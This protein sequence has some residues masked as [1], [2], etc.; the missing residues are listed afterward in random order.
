MG[1]EDWIAGELD[2][3]RREGLERRPA[4]YPE[5]GGK[6]TL[7]GKVFLNLASNDYLDLSRHPAVISAAAGALRVFGAGATA[8]RLVTGTLSIHCELEAALAKLKGYPA[9]LAF[10]SGY[11]AN[12]GVIASLAGRD[13]TVLVDKLAH[14]SILDAV[15]LSRARLQRFRHNDVAHLEELLKKD[16]GTGR[17]LVVTESVFS[18]DGDIAPL[19]DIAAAASKASAMLMVDEAHATGVFGPGGSG[20]VRELGL[21]QDVN[22]SMGTLSK[23]LGGYGGF[24][25]CSAQMRELMINTARPF[26]FSTG[27]PPA[28]AASALAAIGVMAE[29]PGMGRDLLENAARLRRRLR[30]AGLDTGS[31]SSQIVPV[32]VGENHIAVEMAERLKARGILVAAIRP[33]TVP[34]GTARLRLSVSLAH[35]MADLDRA[36][37]EVILAVN[38]ARAR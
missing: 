6:I 16:C 35:S 36:A 25:A 26:I 1:T 14:A 19:R 37:D 11:M 9:A 33:P 8:S 32:I 20:L 22:V 4:T 38:A 31:S 23:A 2:S 21:E 29:R 13:D 15:I 3:R 34:A 27:L 17:R 28:S 5:A 30:D 10:G 18:M 12:A 7:D 24:I